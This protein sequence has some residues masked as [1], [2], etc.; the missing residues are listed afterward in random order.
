M[1]Q[2]SLTP[3]LEYKAGSFF[4]AV[5]AFPLKQDLHLQNYKSHELLG[6]V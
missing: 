2:K 4:S 3:T 6:L 1:E 5:S